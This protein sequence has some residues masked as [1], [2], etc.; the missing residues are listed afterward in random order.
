MLSDRCLC[1]SCLSVT[2][3][4]CGQTVEWI[5]IPLGTEADLGAAH[6]VL[7][8]D[9]AVPTEKGTAAPTF[10]PTLLWHGR[11]S[12]QLL[13]SYLY[14]LHEMQYNNSHAHRVANFLFFFTQ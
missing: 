12:Q 5:K 7:D 1:L 14:K 10:R 3:V 4:Y 8:G 2:L 13:S 11:P 6:I 9:P